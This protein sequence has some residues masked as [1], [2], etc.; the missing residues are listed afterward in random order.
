MTDK[1]PDDGPNKGS[2][3]VG[4]VHS[5]CIVNTITYNNASVGQVLCVQMTMHDMHSINKKFI[6]TALNGLTCCE[7]PTI[8]ISNAS[9]CYITHTSAFRLLL[10]HKIN[11]I[12]LNL[13]Y[14][15]PVT[16]HV[17]IYRT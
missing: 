17:F 2:K 13:I 14:G 16:P 1:V 4:L 7:G 10:L 8:Q 5:D 15:F 9:Q 6:H 3:H 12:I 11:C